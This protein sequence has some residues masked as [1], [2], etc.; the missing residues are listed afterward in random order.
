MILC[1]EAEGRNAGSMDLQMLS[2][3]L[4]QLKARQEESFG[5]RR[6]GCLEENE[7]VIK[8]CR[9]KEGFVGG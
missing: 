7:D 4:I 8:L 9:K 5:R 2:V 6:E 3:M 1:R